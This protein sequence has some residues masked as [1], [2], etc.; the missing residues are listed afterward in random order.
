MNFS[1]SIMHCGRYSLGFGLKTAILVSRIV[2]SFH[3][4]AALNFITPTRNHSILHGSEMLRMIF[5]QRR[6]WTGQ[7]NHRRWETEIEFIVETLEGLGDW[8]RNYREQTFCNT[9]NDYKL[10]KKFWIR[11][12]W[13][14]CNTYDL[15]IRE[16]IHTKTTLVTTVQTCSMRWMS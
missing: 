12:P 8:N 16:N 4:T 9:T 3:R 6:S 14:I 2:W 7:C 10:G 11:V 5:D 1:P 13:C 15:R